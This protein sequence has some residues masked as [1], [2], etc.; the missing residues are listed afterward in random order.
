MPEVVVDTDVVSYLF[1]KDTRSRLYRRHL[2]GNGLVVSFMTL[3]ELEH[4]ALC[5]AGAWLPANVYNVS[6]SRT[7]F[8]TPI[9]AYAACGPK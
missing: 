8:M 9:P 1:K 2:L 3:A 4:W 7:G 6:C 5:G